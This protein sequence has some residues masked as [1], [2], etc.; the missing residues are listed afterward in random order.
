MVD[1]NAT[2]PHLGKFRIRPAWAV[3]LFALLATSGAASLWAAQTKSAQPWVFRS[4]PWVFLVFVLG[5]ALYRVALV[6]AGR[7]SPF[8]AFAQVF[9]G[10]LFFL[11]LAWPDMERGGASDERLIRHPDAKVRAM[12]AELIGL[13]L[14]VGYAAQ[15]AELLDDQDDNVRQRAHEALVKLNQGSDLG[16]EVQTWKD[17]F[18]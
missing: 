4:A 14:E 16:L 15:L 1:L 10:I 18:R 6:L 13:K 3:T 5:F 17:R 9:I 11:V 8:K 12:S 2:E 7:Y